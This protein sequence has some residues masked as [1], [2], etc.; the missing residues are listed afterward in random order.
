METEKRPSEQKHW[1]NNASLLTINALVTGV[2][3]YMHLHLQMLRHGNLKRPS[4]QKHWL[5]NASL[6]TIKALVTKNHLAVWD[7]RLGG[8]G[9]ASKQHEINRLGVMWTHTHKNSSVTV[10]FSIQLSPILVR[11]LGWGSFA[12]SLKMITTQP[13]T[14]GMALK[15][16]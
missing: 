6:F 5:N 16:V 2:Y 8:W 13:E 12:P 15:F 14:I 9:Y 3:T 10:Y 11:W 1:L 7:C 4:E